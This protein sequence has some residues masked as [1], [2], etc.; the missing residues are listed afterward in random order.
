MFFFN[1]IIHIA[2]GFFLVQNRRF[3]TVFN[4]FQQ[5]VNFSNKREYFFNVPAAR[6]G[7]PTRLH[8]P[9]RLA[10]GGA[11]LVPQLREPALPRANATAAPC[12]PSHLREPARSADI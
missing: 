10:S 6:S 3:S 12:F 5:P 8:K 4:N 11:C 9:A 2:P 7:L 1:K